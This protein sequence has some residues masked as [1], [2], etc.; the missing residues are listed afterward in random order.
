[1]THDGDVE[2]AAIPVPVS[3]V[4]GRVRRVA[5]AT[6]LDAD[7]PSDPAFVVHVPAVVLLIGLLGL[8]AGLV[9]A[10]VTHDVQWSAIGALSLVAGI[11]LR[12]IANR[13]TFS[14]GE[15]VV[16]YKSDLGWPRGV[17]ED[18]DLRWSWATSGR[19]P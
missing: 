10:I 8:V 1:M 4:S 15:G 14:F 3:R 9:L 18:D 11:A 13:V 7:P 19:R 16:A 2:R 6:P 17:Q 12:R 5:P